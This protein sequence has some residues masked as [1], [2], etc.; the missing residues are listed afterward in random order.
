MK[1]EDNLDVVS[2][3][4]VDPSYAQVGAPLFDPTEPNST[5]WYPINRATAL[6][7]TIVEAARDLR[8]LAAP[9]DLAAVEGDKR[10]LKLL[11][12]PVHSLAGNVEKL[13]R[14]AV[15]MQ[16]EL[17]IRSTLDP[18]LEPLA[19]HLR[20]L[21][22]GPLRLVR[23]RRVAHHDATKL[24]GPVVTVPLLLDTMRPTLCLW[25]LLVGVRGVYGWTRRPTLRTL[26]RLEIIGE[27]PPG[28]FLASPHMLDP[29]PP[30]D[31]RRLV[32]EELEDT[33]KVHNALALAAEP[34]Q[35]V[36]LIAGL[37]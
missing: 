33:V 7:T 22:E 27:Y 19:K 23:N 34:K 21:L 4:W 20:Q 12:L 14:L 5:H 11:A 31:P 36:M 17:P 35:H 37:P 10:G 30:H 16:A 18:R 28:V 1:R 26:D 29:L 24:E 25:L 9:L 2:D 13:S 6:L 3:D 15:R 32:Y 8:H